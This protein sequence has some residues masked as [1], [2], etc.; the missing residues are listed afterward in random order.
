MKRIAPRISIE[1]QQ[2]NA[3]TFRRLSLGLVDMAM[4]LECTAPN[5]LHSL[6]LLRSQAAGSGAKRTS[7]L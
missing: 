3:D 1:L 7:R 4:R 6:E 5:E 2:L